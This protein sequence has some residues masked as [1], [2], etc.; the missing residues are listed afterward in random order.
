MNIKPADVKD[1]AVLDTL[2][3]EQLVELHEQAGAE[4]EDL[5]SMQKAIRDILYEK[6][7]MNGEIIGD[8]AVTKCEKVIVKTTVEQAEEFGAVTEEVD[9]DKIPLDLARSM[10]AVKKTV[11]APM[12]RKL[13][14]KGAKIPGLEI[15]NY[16]M[17]R[18]AVKS[19]NVD[20]Q[21]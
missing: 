2:S 9:T 1:P 20:D 7:D 4:A 18:S 19:K 14:K 15:V 12:V 16:V 21:V 6:I 17:I 11:N 5:V 13:Y 10:D 8:K 3:K